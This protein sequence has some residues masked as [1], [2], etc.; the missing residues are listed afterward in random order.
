[1]NIYSEV[2]HGTVVRIYLPRARPEGDTVTSLAQQAMPLQSA[3]AVVLVVEDNAEV[4]RSVVGQLAEMGF[5]VLE[6]DNA[7]SALATLSDRAQRIDVLFTD[8]VMPGGMNGRELA[9]AA[10]AQRP[11]IK[12]LFTSGYPGTVWSG[13]ADGADDEYFLGKPYRKQELA[14]KLRQVLSHD[15]TPRT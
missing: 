8:L 5:T 3:D 14:A 4:R 11:E 12:V 1:V 10:A 13:A 7:P 6:A 15:T 2:G 9:R